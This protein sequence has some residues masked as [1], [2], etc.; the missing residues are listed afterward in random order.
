[1]LKLKWRNYKMNETKTFIQQESQSSYEFGKSTSRHK[2]YYWTV[3][4][5]KQ[6]IDGIKDV[7]KD[8][9]IKEFLEETNTK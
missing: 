9:N 5:L 2:V 8:A 7:M 4:E 3:E 6:K 1:M